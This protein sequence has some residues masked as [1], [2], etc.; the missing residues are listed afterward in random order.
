MRRMRDALVL[1]GQMAL[2][3]VII[4]GAIWLGSIENLR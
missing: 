1:A 3:A 4:G 2:I